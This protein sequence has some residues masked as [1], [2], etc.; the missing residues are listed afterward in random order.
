MT[1]ITASIILVTWMNA[2]P[3][4]RTQAAASPAPA[5]LPR[6]QPD[7][8]DPPADDEEDLAEK[9][10]RQATGQ[11]DGGVMGKIQRLM[12]RSA[13]WL[14]GDFDPGPK[15]Q[16]AQRQIIASL[17][18][19]IAAAQ[20]RRS[21][22]QSSDSQSSDKRRGKP[23]SKKQGQKQSAS[24]GSST[25]DSNTKAGPAANTRNASNERFKES[26]RG[27]GHLPARDRDE[28]LQG[29]DESVLEKYRGLIDRYFRALAEDAGEPSEPNP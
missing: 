11:S 1:A 2:A 7:P 23:Q 14:T 25:P 15:T 6:Q 13:Q 19:A 24:S 5:P 22:S 17:D 4:T 3:L 27:W 9:L 10:I 21:R 8:Q 18:D 29:I 20:R 16:A 26:R 28:V 12:E